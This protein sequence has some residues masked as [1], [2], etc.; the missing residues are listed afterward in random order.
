MAGTTQQRDHTDGVHDRRRE[1]PIEDMHNVLVFTRSLADGGHRTCQ[2]LLPITSEQDYNAVSLIFSASHLNG[3]DWWTDTTERPPKQAVL[4]DA[5]PS[6]AGQITRSER[7]SVTVRHVDSP[8]NLTQIGIELSQLPEELAAVDS[9]V[10]C[11]R[12]LTTLLQYVETEP[13]YRFL[14]LVTDRIVAMDGFGHFHIDP[15]A[16]SEQTINTLAS[17]FDAVLEPD[18]QGGLTPAR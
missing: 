2:N 9:T 7:D 1:W 11:V 16:H 3:T 17:L 15:A 18:E 6:P 8:S 14:N 13:A 4:I 10:V 12:S 5:T